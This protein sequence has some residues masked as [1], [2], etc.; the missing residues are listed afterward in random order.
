M[1]AITGAYCFKYATL[2]VSNREGQGGKQRA[3]VQPRPTRLS[4]VDAAVAFAGIYPASRAAKP[5]QY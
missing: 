1:A 5:Q 2:P 4:P 3:A